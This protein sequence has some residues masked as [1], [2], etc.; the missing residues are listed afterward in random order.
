MFGVVGDAELNLVSPLSKS[1]IGFVEAV[2]HCG[3]KSGGFSARSADDVAVSLALSVSTVV[4]PKETALVFGVV[5]DAALNLVSPLNKFAMGFAEAVWHCGIKSGGVSARS[6]D[7]VAVSLAFFVPTVIVAT[8]GL[9]LRTCLSSVRV[10]TG[11]PVETVSED[12]ES[13]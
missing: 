8:A 4:V 9:W 7:D 11:K 10:C 6:A 5:D 13:C 12:T 3:I 1:A 2:W